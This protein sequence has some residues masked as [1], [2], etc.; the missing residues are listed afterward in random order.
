MAAET[1]ATAGLSLAFQGI[2]IRAVAGLEAQ[3]AG[4]SCRAHILR[5]VQP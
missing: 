2:H 3:A 5:A 1:G 4:R